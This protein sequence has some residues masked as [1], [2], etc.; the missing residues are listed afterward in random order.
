MI[1]T[2]GKEIYEKISIIVPIYNISN[3]LDKCIMS[4][5][6]QTY[7]N[8]EM[9]LVDDGSTDES[10][11]KCEIYAEKDERIVVVHQEN[12][13]LVGARK[14]GLKIAKGKYI[15]FV[16]GDDWIEPDMYEGLYKEIVDSD[17]DFIHSYFISGNIDRNSELKKIK[18]DN[19]S[20]TEKLKTIRN[21]VSGDKEGNTG[22]NLTPSIWSKLFKK[23]FIRQCYMDVPDSQPYG[24]DVISLCSCILNSREYII[25]TASYYHYT[26]RDQS[27]S[28]KVDRGRIH[29]EYSLYK[30]L[31]LLFEKYGIADEIYESMEKRLDWCMI[32]HLNDIYGQCVFDYSYDG[33]EKCDGKKIVIYGAGRVGRCYYMQFKFRFGEKVVAWVD[34]NA[35]LYDEV[36]CVN[37]AESICDVDFD[38][39]IVAVEKKEVADNIIAYLKSFGISEENIVWNKPKRILENIS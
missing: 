37:A 28:N 39:I 33:I 17:A 8:I 5:C 2:K 34:K 35:Y 36:Y 32:R 21:I 38:I 3:Y 7:R 18:V 31:K 6:T 27:M 15:G 13:G 16:D 24:E 30:N 20:M 26:I 22:Y 12:R 29:K 11:D 23:D 25:S 14:T 1:K 10:G 9:I 19:S 4:L